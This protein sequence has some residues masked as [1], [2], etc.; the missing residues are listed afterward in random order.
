M[1]WRRYCDL[2]TFYLL[3]AGVFFWATFLVV[4]RLLAVFLLGTFL[5]TAFFF[6]AFFLAVVFFH[7][8]FLP[9]VFFVGPSGPHSLRVTE[10]KGAL[11]IVMGG[12]G[13]FGLSARSG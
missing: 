6:V 8:A 11:P 9:A 7:T 10:R 1:A 5:V 3:P 4:A 13:E 12:G 2:I